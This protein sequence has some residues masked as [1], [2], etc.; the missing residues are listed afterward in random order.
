MRNLKV[1]S[2]SRDLSLFAMEK[3]LDL[4]AGRRH[5]ALEHQRRAAAPPVKPST[6]PDMSSPVVT[7]ANTKL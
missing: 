1:H 2:G 6:L 4:T 3:L 5:A 7:I